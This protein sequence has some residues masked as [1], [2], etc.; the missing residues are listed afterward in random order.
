MYSVPQSIPRTRIKQSLASRARNAVYSWLAAFWTASLN[1]LLFAQERGVSSGA[2]SAFVPREKARV[3][4]LIDN[5]SQN[6]K[7]ASCHAKEAGTDGRP[8]EPAL[9][10]VE[11]SSRA[12]LDSRP[13]FR[14]RPSL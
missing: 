5:L 4:G 7:Q 11:G 10:E 14:I 6:G 2:G 3:S 13:A 9:S 1:P 8:R 12:M